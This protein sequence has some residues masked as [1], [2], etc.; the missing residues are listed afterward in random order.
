MNYITTTKLAQKL[1][2]DTKILFAELNEKGWIKRNENNKW[3]LTEL[4]SSNGGQLRSYPDI[5]EFIVWPDNTI[6]HATSS[7]SINVV[8]MVKM[9]SKNMK[10]LKAKII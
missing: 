3:I 1:R 5:G 4:G 9:T 6:F 7:M 8:S 2:M 10:H